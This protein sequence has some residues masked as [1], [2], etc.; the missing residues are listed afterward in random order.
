MSTPKA[1]AFLAQGHTPMMAQYH[2]LR[3]Q[4]H[5]VHP[6]AILLYR[7]GEFY[8]TF[9]DDAR[10]AAPILGIALTSRGKGPDGAP[11][12]LAGVPA[13]ALETNLAALVRAGHKVA[14][15]EEHADAAPIAARG[16]RPGQATPPARW[17]RRGSWLRPNP[18]IWPP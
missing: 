17:W 8:E 7:I 10:I 16:G 18:A 13:V 1:S 3:A 6:G 11:V 2:A 15:C 5:A 14:L 12:S 4:V 9:E